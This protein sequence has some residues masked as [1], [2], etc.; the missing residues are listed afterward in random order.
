MTNLEA[1]TLTP[2]HVER[3]QVGPVKTKAVRAPKVAK[4]R[5]IAAPKPPKAARATNAGKARSLYMSSAG[6]TMEEIEKATS[7][8]QYVVLQKFRKE[9]DKFKVEEVFETNSKGKKVKRYFVL[10]LSL[11]AK[12][13]AEA[14]A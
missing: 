5:K 12:N 6:A 8:T 1:E 4:P 14:S 10:P 3:T 11:E 2:A 13:G 7:D 9:P